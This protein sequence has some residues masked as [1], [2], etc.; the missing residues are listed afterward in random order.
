MIAAGAISVELAKSAPPRPCWTA[1]APEARRG[2]V[3]PWAAGAA[4]L[5]LLLCGANAQVRRADEDQV[6][7]AYLYNFAKFVE[8][9]AASFTH[10][11]D[12]VVICAM[13][14]EGLA[15]VLQ[16][17]ARGKQA[18]GRPIAVQLVE[19]IDGLK[20]CHILM[21]ALRDKA[22]IGPAL[23]NAQSARILTVGQSADF[24]RLGGMINLVRNED[25][26]ELEINPKAAET[27][28]LKIS[29]RLL[30]VS[31]VI[32]VTREERGRGNENFP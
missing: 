10:P 17:I 23:R 31:H 14:D 25:S 13:G 2:W 22:R 15:E 1:A 3:R 12:P 24:I 32:A 18:Q 30:A 9:P 16:Q 7:A 21:I 27:A 19:S 29:S 26:V 11:D 5:C 6:K 28:G 8:W 20:P 4:V